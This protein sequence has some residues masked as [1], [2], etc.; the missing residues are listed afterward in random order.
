MFLA[1]QSIF[2]KCFMGNINF[3]LAV[4]TTYTQHGIGALF[5]PFFFAK[6]WLDSDKSLLLFDADLQGR[7]EDVSFAR[8]LSKCSIH[9]TAG[10][11]LLPEEE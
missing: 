2:G 10:K 6:G 7:K 4:R 5:F 8:I 11:R 1:R 3:T 9:S